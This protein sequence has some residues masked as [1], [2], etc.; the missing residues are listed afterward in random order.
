MTILKTETKNGIKIYHVDKDISDEEL[1][2]KAGKKLHKDQIKTIIDHD[3]DVFTADGRILLR[4]RKAIL[5]KI[6]MDAFYENIIDF[7]NKET[8]NRGTASGS[9]KKAAGYNPKIKSNIFGY[10]DGWSPRQKM[11]FTQKGHKIPIAIRECTFNRDNPDKFKA[12]IPLIEDID[13]QYKRLAPEYYEKQIKKANQTHFRISKTSFT[14]VTT[15][16]NWQSTLHTDKGDDPEGFG[17]LAVLERGV[18]QG[19]ETCFLQ[20][21]IGVDVRMGDILFMDVHQYHANL[22]IIL[23]EKDSTRLSIVCYL[24]IRVWKNS[25]NKSRQFYERHNKTMKNILSKKKHVNI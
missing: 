13:Q 2:K 22:P 16:V 10:F 18:Y 12:T 17:N 11:V 23:K 8:S 6:H 25:A 15:N 19:G 5:P 14:T 9:K 1:E 7:A 4:F 3:A 21:G 20:Y 24:R